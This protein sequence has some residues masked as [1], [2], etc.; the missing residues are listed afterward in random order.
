MVQ[1]SEDFDLTFECNSIGLYTEYLNL[2]RK[3]LNLFTH[4]PIKKRF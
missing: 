2:K 4:K 1:F 3:Y